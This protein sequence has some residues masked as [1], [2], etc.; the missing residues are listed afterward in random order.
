MLVGI[1]AIVLA[2]LHGSSH[3]FQHGK[4]MT[5]HNMLFTALLLQAATPPTQ[6][7]SSSI[8]TILQAA[9]PPTQPS[10]SSIVTILQAATPPTQP[11]SSSIVTILQAATPPAQPSSS[12]IVTI[13][14]AATP[15]TQPSSSSIVQQVTSE[16]ALLDEFPVS[17]ITEPLTLCSCLNNDDLYINCKQIVSDHHMQAKTAT[18]KILGMWIN[19]SPKLTWKDVVETLFCYRLVNKAV[20]LA[21]RHGVDWEPIHDKS[22]KN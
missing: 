9:T 22:R 19:Q 11:S 15:P 8:V 7:S 2:F 3:D 21:E 12:S 5:F 13:L 1:I 18:I 20:R 17:H 10:S 4:H 16:K 14:Q 6:P